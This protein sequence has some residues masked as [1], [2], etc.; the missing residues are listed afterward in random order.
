LSEPVDF[1]A[2][3]L[4]WRAHEAEAYTVKRGPERVPEVNELRRNLRALGVADLSYFGE[5]LDSVEYAQAPRAAI[6]LAWTGLMDLLQSKL[7]RDAFAALNA[8][9]KTEFHGV[10]KRIGQIKT[11]EALTD[12]FDDA[13]LL[14]AGRKLKFYDKHVL[15][16]LQA[17][18]DERNNC[19]HVQ[20][21]AVSVRIALGFYAHVIEFV[22]YFI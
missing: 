3:L 11:R 9:L 13:M 21:Y 16:Q 14:E 12:A 7:A 4:R 15:M 18:R 2:R 20:E 5:G 8:I 19:A 22:P 17:M 1:I 6:V 10:Y